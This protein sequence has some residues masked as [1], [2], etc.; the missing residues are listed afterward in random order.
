[1]ESS[2]GQL[3]LQGTELGFGW[4]GVLDTKTRAMSATLVSREDLFVPF[5]AYAPSS[6]SE[7]TL[8]SEWPVLQIMQGI[9]E[10]FIRKPLR[11]TNGLCLN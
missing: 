2:E 7:V 4:C 5:A 1:M 3:L 10:P 9:D 8:E 6:P 11:K